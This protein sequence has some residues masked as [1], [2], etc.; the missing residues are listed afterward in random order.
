MH[1]VFMDF[2]YGL[3]IKMKN[4]VTYTS[5]LPKELLEQLNEMAKELNLPKNKIIERSLRLYLKKLK[6]AEYIR[7]FQRA[8]QDEE[9]MTLAEEGMEDYLNMVD[10]L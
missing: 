1:I 6:K 9:M 8:S 10:E 2:I 5:S 3:P 7:S 4:T